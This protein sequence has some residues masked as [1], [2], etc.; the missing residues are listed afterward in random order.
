M[1]IQMSSYKYASSDP[2]YV[3]LSSSEIE[4]AIV[5]YMGFHM[6]PLLYIYTLLAPF[7]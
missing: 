6:G 5:D 4:T 2:K 3:Y 1:K 7:R